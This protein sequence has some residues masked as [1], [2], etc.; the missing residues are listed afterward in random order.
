MDQDWQA[1]V[2]A[3]EAREQIRQLPARYVWAS[4]RCDVDAMVALF[5]EDCLFESPGADG[6]MR[7]Q[8]REPLHAMLSKSLTK[9]GGIIALIHNQIIDLHGSR[10]TGTCAMSN[11][12]A[13]AAN[14]PFVG[15]Y[16]DDFRREGDV[17]F[18]SARRFY[19][20][21]PHLD[22]SGG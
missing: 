1:R 6:R 20:Y 16:R 22:L 9:P 19:T 17:W 3:L 11:P 14:A 15:Y 12:V 4:A 2:V 5:T 13:P 10:A 18:Y 8:G 7:L 21:S